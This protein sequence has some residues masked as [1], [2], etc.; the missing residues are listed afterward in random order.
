[1]CNMSIHILYC[2]VGMESVI[3][4]YAK[5]M[6]INMLKKCTKIEIKCTDYLETS[7]KTHQ[8]LL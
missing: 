1:M 4:I 3:I 5:Y 6:E 2:H 7:S 8:D